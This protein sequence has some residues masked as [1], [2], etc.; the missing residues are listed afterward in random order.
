MGWLKKYTDGGKADS[1]QNP[2]IYVSDVPKMGAGGDPKDQKPAPYITHDPN[3][4]R[5]QAHQDS[6]EVYNSYKQHLNALQ[7]HG[8]EPSEQRGHSWGPF[9]TGNG[10]AEVTNLDPLQKGI[11]NYV[12]YMSKTHPQGVKDRFIPMGRDRFM[13]KDDWLSDGVENDENYYTNKE[14]P[15]TIYNKNIQPKSTE[16]WNSTEDRDSPHHFFGPNKFPEHFIEGDDTKKHLNQVHNDVLFNFDYSNAQAKQDVIYQPQPSIPQPKPEPKPKPRVKQQLQSVSLSQPSFPR[17]TGEPQP[18]QININD[19]NPNEERWLTPYGNSQG[20][21]RPA[22][23]YK[24]SM[25]PG[26]EPVPTRENGGKV[27]TKWLKK[28]T[29]GGKWDDP[30]RPADITIT[31]ARGISAGTQTFQGQ[32]KNASPAERVLTPEEQSYQQ[33]MGETMRSAD[34][35]RSAMDKAGAIAR[36]PMT[37]AQYV[38]QGQPIPDYFEKGDRN[39]YDYAADVL[40]PMTYVDAAK[41]TATLEHFRNMKSLQ[42]LP[43]AAFNTAMDAGALIGLGSELRAGPNILSVES[44]TAY[45]AGELVKGVG[46]VG[47]SASKWLENYGT[48]KSIPSM[49]N[50]F[51]NGAERHYSVPSHLEDVYH[52][53]VQQHTDAGLFAPHGDINEFLTNGNFKTPEKA[54]SAYIESPG[55]QRVID[56]S[57]DKSPSDFTRNLFRNLDVTAGERVDAVP[58]SDHD[59]YNHFRLPPT[60][61]VIAANIRGGGSP[62]ALDAYSIRTDLRP[63]FDQFDNE[64]RNKVT[65]LHEQLRNIRNL[66]EEEQNAAHRAIDNETTRTIASLRERYASNIETA[67]NMRFRPAPYDSPGGRELRQHANETRLQNNPYANDIYIDALNR[68]ASRVTPRTVVDPDGNTVEYYETPRKRTPVIPDKPI[69]DILNEVGVSKEDADAFK[70]HLNKPKSAPGM[71]DYSGALKEDIHI[72]DKSILENT[73]DIPKQIKTYEEIKSKLN[74]DDRN[75]AKVIA[76]LNRNLSDLYSTNWL[77]NGFQ[78]ELTLEGKVPTKKN[79]SIHTMGS[80]TKYLID[81]DGKVL[82]N[83]SGIVPQRPEVG[84][85]A[86][87]EEHHAVNDP[88]NNISDA[89]YRGVNQGLMKSYGTNLE[90]TQ[91]FANT[92]FFNPK[93]GKVERMQRAKNYWESR[94]KPRKG[95][96]DL[97]AAE[98]TDYGNIKM[99]RGLAPYIG[100]GVTLGAL[101]SAMSQQDTKQY[102]GTINKT[103]GW[104]SKY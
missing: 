58:K 46:D 86:I 26:G 22:G 89:L 27:S 16:R 63:I 20:L 103:G 40:N 9:S 5:I 2:P 19:W 12:D 75:H 100:A 85:A 30:N 79:L 97:P 59:W 13:V 49:Y 93:T 84:A 55:G 32:H 7:Q 24:Q 10:E 104:L 70:T 38:V 65:P 34:P 66:P 41:R 14:L 68:E 74:P 4:P 15:Y 17:T 35:R 8:Y 94:L 71:L 64:W 76:Q 72:R 31:P 96:G 6:T 57:R 42:D 83:I 29:D 25:I 50:P 1:K 101:K 18:E 61:D 53:I 51:I 21:I 90:T 98:K 78:D 81:E 92:E 11:N 43:G 3:D 36:N 45:Q 28:Y 87:L 88:N 82:G 47:K 44:P 77:R 73:E 60:N 52:N 23:F 102:G 69:E 67:P 62:V 54:L 95:L 48:E 80:G 37:A 99:V 91:N 39:I 56:A 33:I